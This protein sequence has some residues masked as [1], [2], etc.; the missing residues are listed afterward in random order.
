MGLKPNNLATCNEAFSTPFVSFIRY[1][2]QYIPTFRFYLGSLSREK[3]D[4]LSESLNGHRKMDVS[5]AS[6][7]RNAKVCR[8]IR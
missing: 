2:Y 7:Q 6:E 3:Q 4:S 8:F 1:Q 5:T